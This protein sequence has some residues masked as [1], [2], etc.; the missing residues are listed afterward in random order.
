[1]GYKKLCQLWTDVSYFH[2]NSMDKITTIK[3]FQQFSTD[4]DM[5]TLL[6]SDVLLN[7]LTDLRNWS[8][9]NSGKDLES[10]FWHVKK[11]ALDV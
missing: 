1:M 3:F 2:T 7:K 5:V 8:M 11:T 6:A 4:N 10:P 9:L